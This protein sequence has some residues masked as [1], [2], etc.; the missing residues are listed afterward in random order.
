MPT[1]F[2]NGNLTNASH[3]WEARS[4]HWTLLFDNMSSKRLNEVTVHLKFKGPC[5]ANCQ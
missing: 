3:K 4:N 1:I 5:L 2:T